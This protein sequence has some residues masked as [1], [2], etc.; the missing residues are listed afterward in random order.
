MGLARGVL[1]VVALPVLLGWSCLGGQHE[2]GMPASAPGPSGPVAAQRPADHTKDKH[3]AM[4]KPGLKRPADG[5]CPA[6]HGA[7]LKGADGAP[8]CFQCHGM[9]WKR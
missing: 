1:A 8:S 2:L 7:D 6:C 9:K 4:H 3:G 5:G